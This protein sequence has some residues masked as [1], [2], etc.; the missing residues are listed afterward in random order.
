M[1]NEKYIRCDVIILNGAAYLVKSE[2]AGEASP[3][4]TK[5]KAKQDSNETE[6]EPLLDRGG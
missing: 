1:I 4:K 3:G 6:H 5:K 2:K